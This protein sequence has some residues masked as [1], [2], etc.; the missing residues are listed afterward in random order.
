MPQ[1]LQLAPCTCLHGRCSKTTTT[2]LRFVGAT[3]I[4][5]ITCSDQ[6]EYAWYSSPQHYNKNGIPIFYNNL[7]LAASCLLSGYAYHK[8]VEMMKF[9]GL[10]CVT[11]STFHRY[12]S[13]YFVPTI[14]KFW[15]EHQKVILYEHNSR[16]LVVFGDGCCDSPGSSAALCT[17]TVMDNDSG[18]IL[19]T[20]TVTKYIHTSIVHVI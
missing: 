5:T 9:M 16:G 4:M 2:K 10:K 19:S 7:F 14:E 20:I 3:L 6:H 15:C 11:N 8:I 13:T 12:Q 1:L 18:S 17:Y